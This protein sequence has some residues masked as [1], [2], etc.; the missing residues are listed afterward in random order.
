MWNGENTLYYGD[1]LKILQDYIPDESVDLI[2]LD[3]P[4]NSD[5]NYNVLFKDESGESSEAQIEAFEDTWHWNEITEALYQEL[6]LEIDGQVGHVIDALRQVIGSN[7]MMAYLVMMARRLVE[8]QR[9]L[10]PNGSLYLHCDPTA[11]HYLK[12][13]LDSIFGVHN[14]KNEIVWLRSAPKSH[15]FTRYP[16]AHDIILFYG[17]SQNTKWNAIF[18]GHRAE[19]IESHYGNIEPETGRRYTLG[20][21]LNPNKDRPNLTYEFPPGSGSVR[22]WRWTKERMM[23]A[24]EE[25]RI[26]VPKSGG[27]PRY[28]RYLDE[29]QGT[30][31][32]SVWTDI[33]PINSQAQERLGYPTQ[34]PLPLL[35]RIIQASSNEGDVV[36]DPFAG[37]G[38]AIVA[39][40]KLGRKWVGIDIT[41]L[42]IGLLKVR[43]EGSFGLEQDKDYEVVGEPVDLA[44]AIELANNKRFQFQ[45]WA[46]AMVGA[47]P[48]GSK[49]GKTGKKGADR[50]IDGTS[51]F[52]DDSTNKA[53]TIIVQVK[54]G[55][56]KVGDI[57]DLVGTIDREKAAMGIFLTLEQPTG[58]M[59]K[60]AAE[61]GFY[62]SAG[63]NK[64]YP[65]IQILT[66]EDVLKGERPKQPPHSITFKEAPK[67]E[68]YD[69]DKPKQSSMGFE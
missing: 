30:P 26:L 57:R 54:S 63:W 4:F 58:P 2:Y 8:L 20:D 64:Q 46:V 65:R 52:I 35:E 60:E 5:R 28:K 40:E 36:L 19:Y 48:F 55:H 13:I 23:A 34:K 14:F 22:V 61:A 10:K 6:V 33:P 17:N 21:L 16:S 7:Q 53:K 62:F 59:K 27:V 3:P 24:W 29:M 11:S 45:Y 42:A 18:T 44:S 67:V 56:V 49:D 32:T 37:C 69:P 50:G 1:N 12:M 31:V 68:Q 47:R 41:H 15:A 66:I 39:A 43:L 51:F 9:V 38:T 25:G